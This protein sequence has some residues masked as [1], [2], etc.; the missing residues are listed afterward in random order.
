M[1][2]P[3]NRLW[4]RVTGAPACPL[5][6]QQPTVSLGRSQDNDLVVDHASI[7]RHHLLIMLHAGNVVL[8][9][10]GSLN[11]TLVNGEP[12]TSPVLVDSTD[13]ILV[14]QVPMV[15]EAR[16]VAP[17]DIEEDSGL[18]L[19]ASR[20][21][22]AQDFLNQPASMGLVS[23]EVMAVLRDCSLLLVQDQPLETMLSDLLAQA[24]T[25]LQ[26]SRG[27]LLVKNEK[28]LLQQLAG[29]TG[30]G[31]DVPLKLSRAMM[32]AALEHGEAMLVERPA[33][34]TR[35]PPTMSM[36]FT[37]LSSI[38]TVPLTHGGEV[39]GLFY[40]DRGPGKPV[41]T[42][43]DLA[44]AFIL[45]NLAAARIQAKR[46][47]LAMA[48]RQAQNREAG[49]ARTL[50]LRLLPQQ[51]HITE[52]RFQLSAR[53]RPC[54]A[55]SGD[56]FDYTVQ[57]DRLYLCMGD[58]S[59]K[60]IHAVADMGLVKAYLRAHASISESPSELLSAVNERILEEGDSELLVR[61]FCAFLDLR[62]GRL[63]YSSASHEPILKVGPGQAMTSLEVRQGPT[64]GV[65]AKAEFA[66]QFATLASGEELVFGSDGLLQALNGAGVPF[67]RTRL[68][69]AIQ[70]SPSRD[71]NALTQVILSAVDA[72]CGDA[73]QTD[74]IAL[75]VLRAGT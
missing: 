64:L 44:F 46:M 73:P 39:M 62:S 72:Y 65:Q 15:I 29:R 34:D 32:K 8:Q 33:A 63:S 28:G 17:L 26:P 27:A 5:D 16:P 13:D 9:D 52:G 49:L 14:G 56:F 57:G 30:Q 53:L 38:L 12:I 3:M 59:G 68:R 1:L 55:V 71:P 54:P 43:E 7:S 11:G 47:T 70:A 58:V 45:G 22:R 50:Q 35:V 21:F 75:L 61:A 18:P 36:I 10:L 48:E 41:F 2:S 60:G 20:R 51:R 4:I 69:Q 19:E 25:V 31:K 37:G 24:F 74:D 67:G 42:E 66:L 23:A 40:L 6:E